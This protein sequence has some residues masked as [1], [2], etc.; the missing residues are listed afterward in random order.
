VANFSRTGLITAGLL[1]LLAPPAAAAL[2]EA[3]QRGKQIYF[4]GTSPRGVLINAVVGDES[5]LIPASAIPCANCHGYDGLGRPEGGVTPTDVRWSQLAKSYGH[6]HENGRRHDA[7]DDDS[8]SR[9][10]IAGVDPANNRLDTT[11]PLYLLSGADVADLVAYMKVLEFDDDPGVEDDR[12]RVAT[13]LPQQGR[14]A[15]LGAAMDQVLRAHFADVNEQGGVFGRKIDLVTVPLGG[16]PEASIENLQQVFKENDIFALVGGYTIGLDDA[17]LDVLRYD[18]VPLVG[19]FTL[20]PGDTLLDAAAFYLYPGFDVQAEVLADAALEQAGSTDKVLVASPVPG[21]GTGQH[22]EL[23]GIAAKRLGNRS[24]SEA[25]TAN[26]LA[27]TG[28]ATALAENIGSSGAEAVLFFGGK[29]DLD[30]LLVALAIRKLSPKIYVLSSFLTGSMY[31]APKAFDRRIVIG[32]PTLASDV[33]PQ[34]R[35]DYQDLAARHGLPPGHI[36]AQ[37]ASFSAARLLVEGLRRAGRD[38]ARTRLVEGVEALY[39]FETGFTPPLS[40]GPNRRIG[41]LGA[42]LMTVDLENRTQ[43]PVGDGWHERR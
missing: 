43:V 10:I 21:T 19:P 8:L 18:N 25:L 31:D 39:T 15:E 28:N 13:L 9:S 41:A 32:Y 5:T 22:E 7:F 17:L 4:E 27:G 36:Q 16:T 12:V 37:L 38:L 23:A 2:T 26:Y 40:F 35:K 33:S 3:E 30:A 1:G 6:V 11:M 34:G 20:D 29:V 24:Q 42:H 14:A